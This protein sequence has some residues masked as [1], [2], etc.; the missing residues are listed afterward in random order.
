[1]ICLPAATGHAG[2]TS[3]SESKIVFSRGNIN[4]GTA[5]WTVD[6]DGGSLVQITHPPRSA[7]DN[8]PTWSPNRRQVAFVREVVV[9]TDD[10]GDFIRHDHLTVMNADGTALRRLALH[11]H[12]PAWSPAGKLIVFVK[13]YADDAEIW[14]VSPSGTGARR[15]ARGDHPVWSPDGRLIAFDRWTG[16]RPEIFVMNANGSGQRRLLPRFKDWADRPQW[17]PDGTQIAFTG[18]HCDIGVVDVSVYVVDR[19]GRNVRKL[20]GGAVSKDAA[21]PKWS[22]DG[23]QILFEREGPGDFDSTFVISSAGSGLRRIATNTE[24]PAWSPDGRRVAF[25]RYN[26][27]L[28]VV[29]AVDGQPRTLA[30]GDARDI[31]W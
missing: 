4:I 11:G 12:E 15:L 7:L 26:R 1:M 20:A 29:S 9:G 30:R 23:G 24:Y 22:P 31:D 5:I 18:C 8:E 10:R 17:S 27:A 28:F 3:S 6:G 21:E 2:F 19:D 25:A 16:N 13:D 14:A